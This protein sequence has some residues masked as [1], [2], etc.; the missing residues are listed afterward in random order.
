MLFQK[1]QEIHICLYNCDDGY[2]FKTTTTKKQQQKLDQFLTK[3]SI[4]QVHIWFSPCED[5][6][7]PDIYPV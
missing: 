3:A 1:V 4:S 5:L 6:D 7:Q 2:P